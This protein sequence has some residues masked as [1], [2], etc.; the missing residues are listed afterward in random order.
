MDKNIKYLKSRQIQREQANFM[1][2]TDFVK[3][4]NGE[5]DKALSEINQQIYKHLSDM[6]ED[7][8]ISLAEA[9][10]LLNENELKDFK[11][12]LERFTK[13][14]KGNLS[15]DTEIMLNNASN[16]FRISRLQAMETMIEGQVDRLLNVEQK[17]LYKLLGSQYKNTFYHM[18][19]DFQVIKGYDF[20]EGINERKLKTILNKPW[21]PSGQNFSEA[22]WNRK[23]KIIT[24]IQKELT[25]NVIQGKGL[26]AISNDIAKKF[27]TSKY[28]A[29]RLVYTESAAITAQADRDS[30][31]DTGLEKYELIVTLDTRTSEVCRTMSRVKGTGEN[32]VPGVFY[33]KDYKVGITAPPFHPNCRST[34]VPYF[35]DFLEDETRAMRNPITG[36]TEIVKKM[37]YDTWYK[38]YVRTA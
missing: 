18:T 33:V 34:T 19:Y 16:R 2:S 13:L 11:M 3:W 24:D 20:I 8:N 7:N 22:I 31:I 23:S 9:K 6:A 21:S 17:G 10:K 36:K 38:K 28:N 26:K 25:Q 1:E 5:H 15:K 27:E 12:D 4:L 14:A 37:N 35:D 32:G 30:Y 29:R